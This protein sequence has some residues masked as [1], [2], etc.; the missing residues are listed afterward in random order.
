MKQA[1]SVQPGTPQGVPLAYLAMALTL[2]PEGAE[3]REA[4]SNEYIIKQAIVESTT[5][6]ADPWQLR[7]HSPLE[8]TAPWKRDDLTP[9]DLYR[10][11]TA[12]LWEEVDALIVLGVRGGSLGVGQELVWA[13]DQLVPLLYLHSD[14]Q[15]L[16][17]QVLGMALERDLTVKA[18]GPRSPSPGTAS[19][20]QQSAGALWRCASHRRALTGSPRAR[21]PSRQHPSM[22][23]SAWREFSES[24]APRGYSAPAAFQTSSPVNERPSP[25]LLSSASGPCPSLSSS[26]R[27]PDWSLPAAEF[28]AC[29]SEASPT[30]RASRTTVGTELVEQVA[31]RL[32]AIAPRQEPPVDVVA[33]ARALGVDRILRTA[34]V[35]DGRLEQRDGQISIFVRA[36]ARPTRQRFTIAH[37]IG[38]LVLAEPGQDLV[39]RRSQ[40]TGDREERFCDALAAALLLP[41]EWILRRY[42]DAPE[43]LETARQVADACEASLS[44]AVLR[45]RELLNWKSSLL[46][47]RRAD[48]GRWFLS[49]AVGLPYPLRNRVTSSAQTT[50][51][52][53]AAAATPVRRMTEVP[54]LVAGAEVCIRAEI[55]VYG[56][57]AVALVDLRQQSTIR[58]AR[59]S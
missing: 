17:R 49:Q 48:S 14:G 1:R 58:A 19:H 53:A 10:I 8:H 50:R 5:G 37:E 26:N 29:P 33:L 22:R 38:H 32:L 11:N 4:E 31:R 15:D 45:L 34:T 12:L 55:S 23:S 2:L 40:A 9:D 6:A 46:Q 18:F 7:V 59:A 25:M 21:W 43:R 41:R 56:S 30:G 16:S 39:A 54:L 13:G 36:D 52:L 47:W 20:S 42:A 28:V 57:S 3:R 24:S 35:E 51:A 44:A 27:P